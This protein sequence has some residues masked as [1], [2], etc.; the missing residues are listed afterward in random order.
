MHITRMLI[1][2]I[3][4]AA[5]SAAEV[6]VTCRELGVVLDKSLRV[7]EFRG[8]SC[9]EDGGV[10]VGDTLQMVN[11][12]HMA[13]RTFADA[14]RVI[15]SL[16]PPL[17]AAFG[18]AGATSTAADAVQPSRENEIGARSGRDGGE[19][20][21]KLVLRGAMG[22]MGSFPIAFAAFS[23]AMAHSA[24]AAV[25]RASERQVKALALLRIVLPDPPH[26]CTPPAQRSGIAG[27]AVVVRRG[28]C[29]FTEKA[30]VFARLGAAVVVVV[31][32]EADKVFIMP[33]AALRGDQ[34][35]VPAV[36]MAPP[37]LLERLDGSRAHGDVHLYFTSPSGPPSGHEQR[38]AEAAVVRSAAAVESAAA[39]A[40][41]AVRTA[42]RGVALTSFDGVA[43]H[44]GTLV[45]EGGADGAAASFEFL[46]AQFGAALGE[47]G[48]RARPAQRLV[49]AQPRDACV[50]L[51]GGAELYRGA[52]VL[53]RSGICD[54]ERKATQA[55]RAGASVVVV[56]GDAPDLRPP[57]AEFVPTRV[58]AHVLT[59]SSRS[60]A[61]L[62]AAVAA[63]AQ[64]GGG[65]G[66]SS[67]SVRVRLCHS[68]NLHAH[69]ARAWGEL[70]PLL[71][72][73]LE[74]PAEGV[75]R[76]R[77]FKRLHRRHRD[78]AGRDDAAAAAAGET[79]G[80][81]ERAHAVSA[82]F[83]R[84]ESFFLEHRDEL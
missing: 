78:G 40:A 19:L 51:V 68:L 36:V 57:T 1:A 6:V 23:G 5:V 29:A 27:A 84:A 8:R 35:A 53:V 30:V 20:P 82:A 69:H 14:V 18:R 22:D 65:D 49:V 58:S 10:E 66:G 13:G 52:V 33:G 16:S 25:A 72:S 41:V 54:A 73:A 56:I 80:S 38:A 64:H 34:S 28:R 15:Q 4:I 71:A 37:S 3:L 26:G 74:W 59:V 31:N 24:H 62:E 46:L 45:V 67:G 44:A 12:V 7:S 50:P 83:D 9:A 39:A 47:A 76:R 32:N 17:E 43:V 63:A 70:Q 79:H 48:M 75:A 77:L 61:A 2:W 11:A 81:A 42:G 55:Q 21:T 60:G